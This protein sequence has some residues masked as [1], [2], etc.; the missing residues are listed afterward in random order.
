MGL[1]LEWIDWPRLDE[2]LAQHLWR[3]SL[4]RVVINIA[5]PSDTLDVPGLD[6]LRFRLRMISTAPSVSVMIESRSLSDDGYM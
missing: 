2:I 3:D 5:V 1:Q 4:R 6:R